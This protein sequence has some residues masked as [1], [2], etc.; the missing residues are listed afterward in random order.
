MGVSPSFSISNSYQWQ[1][2]PAMLVTQLLRTQQQLLMTAAQEGAYYTDVYALSRSADGKRALMGLIPEA[3]HGT[4]EVV[5]GVQTRDL[6]RKRKPISIY[7]RAPLSPPRAS[8]RSRKC[9]P[10]TPT[11]PC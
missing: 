6:S 5:T 10:A 4:E 11:R 9:Y 7:T 1:N 2:D 3:F 8:K